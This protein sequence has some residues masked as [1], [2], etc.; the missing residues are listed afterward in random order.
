MFC[1]S[2]GLKYYKTSDDKK[3]NLPKLLL[4]L[5]RLREMGYKLE[6]KIRIRILIRYF[7]LGLQ[8]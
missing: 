2:F 7:L 1:P 6:N 3:D 5:Q 8:A 4:A